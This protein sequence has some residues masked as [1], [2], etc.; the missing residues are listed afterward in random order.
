MGMITGW[1]PVQRSGNMRINDSK[2]TTKKELNFL[3]CNSSLTKMQQLRTTTGKMLFTVWLVR[4]SMSS[5]IGI[6]LLAMISNIWC[7]FQRCWWDSNLSPKTLPPNLCRTHT[8]STLIPS[9]HPS[10]SDSAFQ[11][12][13]GPYS[14]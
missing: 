7:M 11:L 12:E 5:D 14:Q 13:S 2:G 1:T 6:I 10:K 9:P 4:L 3:L 8:Q